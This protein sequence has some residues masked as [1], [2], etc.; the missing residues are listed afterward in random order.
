MVGVVI[1]IV[2]CGVTI[3]FLPVLLDMNRYRDWYLPSLEQAFQRPVDVQDV[4]LII[5]PKL[6]VRVR[7]ITIADDLAFS[8]T[9]FVTIPSAEVVVRWAPLLS[10]QIQVARVVLQDPTVSLIRTREGVLNTATIGKAPLSPPSG[11]RESGAADAFEPWY[12]M[13]A[14]ERFAVT[15]GTLSYEDRAREPSRSYQLE[16][17]EFVTNAVQIGQTGNTHMTGMVKPSGLPLEIH[18]RFGPIQPT[19]DV[20]ID[21]VVRLGKVQATAQGQIV[22]GRLE[23]DVQIPEIS[24]SELPVDL[25]WDKPVHL[26]RIQARLSA[27]LF[28]DERMSPSASGVRID[29]LTL[30]L[31][32]GGSTLHLSGKGTP[33]HLFLVGESPVINSQDFPLD[34]GVRR[35]F[36]LEQVRVETLIQGTRIDLIALQA[37]AFQGSLE[38]HGKWDGTQPAPLLS[39]QGTFT[40]F[41]VKPVVQTVRSSSL[42][43]NGTGTLHWNVAGAFPL[44]GAPNLRGPVRLRIQDGHLVGFDLVQAIEEAFQGL[45]LPEESISRAVTFSLIDI[46]ADLEETGLVIRQL[47]ID[48]TDFSLDGLGTI[49]IDHSVKIRGNLVLSTEM[50]DGFIQR[51]PMAKVLA[52]QEG[53]LVLP[54]TV[55][56]TVQEPVL[57]LDVK[58]F[59]DQVQKNVGLRIEKALQGDEEELQ[60][61]LQDGK[62][63][64]KRLF[65]K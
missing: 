7:G 40:H 37:R 14:V 45:I 5:F 36:P 16:N 35:P 41:A 27:A 12:G 48:A 22:E 1:V 60:Q 51:F 4:R 11:K 54:F 15:G 17:L 21:A 8:P 29:P 39:L 49:G 19:L 3:L 10:R 33:G 32:L 55:K 28:S 30:D 52:Q 43:L 47:N 26:T 9:P 20:P 53:L 13:F 44:S 6:G 2:L 34:L 31:Q 57:Q 56:G 62:D 46:N 63:V 38:A 23:L 64:L 59:R 65:G 18:G 58:S 61:L 24:T 42:S 50:S 25:E